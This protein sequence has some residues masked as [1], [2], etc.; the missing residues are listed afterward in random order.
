MAKFLPGLRGARSARMETKSVVPVEVAF[1]SYY[2]DLAA[3]GVRTNGRAWN[4]D[5]AV[6]EGY[7]R[8][9]WVFKSVNTIGSDSARLPFRL[10]EGD[11]VVDDHPLYRVL[12]KKA[13]PIETGQVFRKRLSAQVQLSKR[14]AFV[15][16][17][18][19]NGGTVKRLD[20]LPPDR[21]EIIPGTGNDLIS[22][23]R[24]A[25]KDGTYR[26][27][28]PENVRWFRDPHPLDPYMGSTPLEAAGLSVELDH[29]ARLY[30]VSFM[31]NDG[32][33]GG[34][35][36]VR[37]TDG[38]GGDID[39]VQMDRIEQRFGKGPV[40]AGKLSVVAGDLSYVDLAARPRDMQYGATS[41]NAKI[42]ILSA[43]GVPESVLGYSAERTF[44]NADNELYVYWTR[45]LPAHHE[46]LLTGF[47]EDSE[48]DLEGFFDTSKVEVLER[49]ERQKREEART[50]FETGLRSIWSYAKLAGLDDEIE[51]TPYTRALYVSQGKTP[52]AARE[53]DMEA[54]GLAPAPDAAAAAPAAVEGAPETPALDPA[55]PEAP[56]AIGAA[57]AS[58]PAADPAAAGIDMAALDAKGLPPTLHAIAGGA[59]PKVQAVLRLSRKADEGTPSNPD[60]D[61]ADRL[62]A[63]LAAVL[64]ALSVR[65]TERAAARLASPKQRKGTRHWTPEFE[66]DTRIGRKALDAARAVD[67][68]TWQ[69]EAEEETTPLLTAAATAAAAALLADLAIDPPEGT[70]MPAYAAA[71][72]APAIDAVVT[73]VRLSVGRQ[74]DVL[75]GVVNEAD[76]GGES[77][78][79]IT[80][81]IREHGR[82]MAPWAHGVSTQA[83][84]AL[85]NGARDDAA[86]EAVR[87][88]PRVDV[89]RQWVSR[90]DAVVRVTHGPA[91]G[92]DGQTRGL[93]EPFIV[94]D[95]LLR[96]PGDPL[97]PAREVFNCRCYLRHRSARTGRFL[98]K[99]R[100]PRDGDGDGRIYDGTPRERPAPPK[101]E[102]TARRARTGEHG[103]MNDR[104]FR[105]GYET[106]F[107]RMKGESAAARAQAVRDMDQMIGQHPVDSENYRLLSGARM[108]LTD[109]HV[110]LDLGRPLT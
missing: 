42:E 103:M 45:T 18:R 66:H 51:E 69:S 40:E 64:T 70:S 104:Q 90:R 83:A 67:E 62:E 27:L 65:W 91:E 60:L 10:R 38:Q 72:A 25:R 58:P 78:E 50:E 88:D 14:G 8:I 54:L 49:A 53:E 31:Q 71:V 30:N 36:A 48:D 59:D 56:A 7:E 55:A 100:R 19:S 81:R 94:G 86:R 35:L 1:Q 46:I 29:F 37:K 79:E 9:I 108:A 47:D 74:A 24:L 32:R 68:E 5:R 107:E 63:A 17:T 20:L 23:F 85:T 110:Q 12:N 28:A 43:F 13:N 106:T 76:Q 98:A 82:R 75:T 89:R 41:R 73:L 77:I 105:A 97:G 16:Y 21:T 57:P 22:H 109:L 101:V 87:V 52:L 3:A 39:P 44:D 26:N 34:V 80:D 33:P 61:A 84:T 96:F 99:A 102:L 95:A 6:S 11:N 2:A 15:E 93:D 92:A 4:I